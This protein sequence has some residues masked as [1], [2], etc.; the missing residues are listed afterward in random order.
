[1]ISCVEFVFP[2]LSQNNPCMAAEFQHNQPGEDFVTT[3][4][5]L[6]K[7]S[8]IKGIQNITLCTLCCIYTHTDIIL[9]T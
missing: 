5:N 7:L 3:A 6:N 4:H 8:N 1:M 2:P 9:H